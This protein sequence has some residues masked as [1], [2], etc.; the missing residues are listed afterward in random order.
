MMDWNVQN[1]H[2]A[3]FGPPGF[4]QSFFIDALQASQ[5]SSS[6]FSTNFSNCIVDMAY[7][8]DLTMYL[9]SMNF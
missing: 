2:E 5:A 3:K 9:I 1:N 6:L 4:V 7:D 8:T